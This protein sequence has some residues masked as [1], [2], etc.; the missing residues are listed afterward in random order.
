M[1]QMLE[2]LALLGVAEM[3]KDYPVL[4]TPFLM[5]TDQQPLSAGRLN[6]DLCTVESK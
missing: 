5:A 1:D 6:R 3:I 4:I 2:G